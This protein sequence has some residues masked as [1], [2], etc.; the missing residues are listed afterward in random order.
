MQGPRVT[1]SERFNRGW[2]FGT[3]SEK[4]HRDLEQSFTNF[5]DTRYKATILTEDS[6]RSEAGATLT[7]G[8]QHT[9]YFSLKYSSDAEHQGT[10]PG[11]LELNRTCNFRVIR[12][13]D[14]LLMAAEL[15]AA[16]AQ[17]YLDQ[18]R[19]RAGLLPV[20]AT[21]DNIF[22]E[23]RLEFALEGIR[24][25]DLIRTKRYDELTV[26]GDRGAGYVEDQS[27]YD[28]SFVDK[29]G[30]GGFLPIPQN[31][32]DLSEGRFTQNQGW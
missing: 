12:Y 29:I 21:P 2:S 28:V 18:V 10:E 11:Q 7:I 22:N 6:I 26:V 17:A 30:T 19:A 14:V 23:R 8:Y 4:L 20:S 24:Y 3:V 5:G 27:V 31:E 16:N 9:G 1:N 13:A 32:I 25:M 15:G